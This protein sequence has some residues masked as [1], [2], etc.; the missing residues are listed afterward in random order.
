MHLIEIKYCEDTRP[1][2]QSEA[3]QR[4]HAD[5]CKLISAKVVALHTILLEVG[6]TCYREHTLNQFNQLGLDQQ[7]ALKL[8]RS[9]HAHSVQYA[10]KLVPTRRAIKNRNTCCSQ[11]CGGGD[12]RLFGANV[13]PF[14]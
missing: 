10:H 7:R 12:S 14:P 5:L 3:A 2:H 9:M 1:G 6:G 4:Q 8:A 11:L 13:S